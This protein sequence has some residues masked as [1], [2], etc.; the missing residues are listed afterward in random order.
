[1]PSSIVINSDGPIKRNVKRHI[2]PS[3]SD[4]NT[5]LSWHS[6]PG[7]CSNAHSIRELVL[8]L[9]S[10]RRNGSYE[11]F[12]LSCDGIPCRCCCCSGVIRFLET[13]KQSLVIH[14]LS[15]NAWSY[16]RL[17]A[18]SFLRLSEGA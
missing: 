8:L 3:G 13:D 16:L 18:Y 4:A 12:L 11:T 7:K 1:M 15:G 17:V 2:S 9:I 5:F 10:F 6:S 14:W